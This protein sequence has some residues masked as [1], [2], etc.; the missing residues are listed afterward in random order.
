M[1]VLQ[2]LMERAKQ[3]DAAAIAV[4]MN[5]ALIS[6]KIRVKAI[7][8]D[9]CLQLMF[10]APRLLN[11][12]ATIAF[13]RRG[14]LRLRPASVVGVR[15][16]AW[17]VDEDFPDW[18]AEFLLEPSPQPSVETVTTPVSAPV[19]TQQVEPKTPEPVAVKVDAIAPPASPLPTAIP[20]PVLVPPSLTPSLTVEPPPESDKTN[21]DSHNSTESTPEPVLEKLSVDTIQITLDE[22]YRLPVA[23]PATTRSSLR[24]QRKKKELTKVDSAVQV[25]VVL[26]FVVMFYFLMA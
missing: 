15:L 3:G 17:Q 8:Q 11:Q 16:Y 18:I 14:I 9:G 26:M 13:T 2:A 1:T 4:L 19:V 10:R 25:S 22:G 20:E 12:H 23:Q 24:S 21:R 6:E 5:D 7:L